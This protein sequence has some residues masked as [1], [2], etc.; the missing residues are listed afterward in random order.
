LLFH[1]VTETRCGQGFGPDVH[2]LEREFSIPIRRFCPRERNKVAG[3][4]QS[5]NNRNCDCTKSWHPPVDELHSI[6]NK[7]DKIAKKELTYKTGRSKN[8][9]VL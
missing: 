7:G 6:E 8:T 4:T 3:Q 9:L 2:K 5:A 1:E